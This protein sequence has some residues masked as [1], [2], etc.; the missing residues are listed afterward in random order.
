MARG[1][2]GR[3]VFRDNRDRQEFMGRV[4]EIVVAGSAQLLAWSLLDNHFHLVLRPRGL[5]LKDLM[6]RLMSGYA[7]WHNRRHGRQGHLF[8]NRYRSIV[9]EEEP[10]LLELIRY[11]H[12][13][14]LRA[15]V[16]P[17]MAALDVYPWTGHAV[18]LGTHEQPGQDVDEVLGRFGTRRAEARRQYRAFVADGIDE[19]RRE[20]FRGGGVVRSAGGW[21]T[22]RRREPEERELGDQ[23]VLGSGAFVEQLL[24]EDDAARF[25]PVHTVDEVLR[26][27][28]RTWQVDA[29]ELI[30]PSRERRVTRARRAFYLC[31]QRDAGVTITEL[32]RLTGRTV[33]A[34]WQAVQRARSAEPDSGKPS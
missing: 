21:E 1:I 22:L 3:P 12:L 19:G 16:I 23:R 17:G 10:Y 9:V 32:A 13:N 5:H 28:S 11:V 8:Q 34:V 20:E 15:G 6:R 26:E 31:A 24:D 25:R 33:P 14:P 30:G 18:L 29:D 7:G 2:E 4:G 27:T